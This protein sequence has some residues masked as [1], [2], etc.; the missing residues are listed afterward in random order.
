M[1]CN[2]IDRRVWD[3]DRQASAHYKSSYDN[4]DTGWG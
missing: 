4:S 3:Q 1:P 2:D